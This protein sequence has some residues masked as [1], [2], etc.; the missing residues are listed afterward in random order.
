M[1]PSS[2]KEKPVLWILFKFLTFTTNATFFY[3][4]KLN[5]IVPHKCSTCYNSDCRDSEWKVKGTSYY[6]QFH[7]QPFGM[8]RNPNPNSPN[9]SVANL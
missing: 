7:A 9:V 4:E 6:L 1:H 8:Q 3:I 2:R 5:C